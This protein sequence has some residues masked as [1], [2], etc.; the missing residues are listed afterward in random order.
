M[1]AQDSSSGPCFG[2]I[3]LKDVVSS[4]AKLIVSMKEKPILIGH[5]MGGLIVPL[6]L[7]DGLGKAGEAIDS[8]P[9][10][11]VSTPKWSLLK[12]NFMMISPFVSK[13]QLREMP[14]KDFQYAFIKTL[15]L[16][17]QQAAQDR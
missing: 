6:K 11:G 3:T 7:R 9:P 13:Y 16:L 4:H 8:A 15:P 12:S 2:K 5:S 17:D 10:A 1:A 14:F